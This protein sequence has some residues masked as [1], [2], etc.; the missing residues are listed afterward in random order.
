MKLKFHLNALLGI[1]YQGMA[2]SAEMDNQTITV[3][4]WS[5]RS[6]EHMMFFNRT[7]PTAEITLDKRIIIENAFVISHRNKTLPLCSV[8]SLPL[9]VF[10][11]SDILRLRNN[12]GCAP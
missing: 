6:G 1:V 12:P 3:A 8:P 7:V 5:A 9:S 2:L 10:Q 11:T 4:D